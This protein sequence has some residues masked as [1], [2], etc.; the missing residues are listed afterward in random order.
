MCHFL[1]TYLVLAMVELVEVAK[2]VQKHLDRCCL[3]HCFHSDPVT[4]F[5]N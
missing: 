3:F 1:L 4:M 2:G 5:A